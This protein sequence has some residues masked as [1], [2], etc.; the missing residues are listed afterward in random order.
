M[1]LHKVIN[2]CDTVYV[3]GETGF[4]KD[5]VLRVD[6]HFGEHPGPSGTHIINLCK[7]KINDGPMIYNQTC[8]YL[9][10]TYHSIDIYYLRHQLMTESEKREFIIDGLI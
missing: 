4:F 7:F 6:L 3:L 9:L 2:E 10:E 1:V 5:R 8:S